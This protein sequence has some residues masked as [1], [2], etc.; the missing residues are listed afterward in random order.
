MLH[1]R[2]K[3]L[4]NDLWP[5][6]KPLRQEQNITKLFDMVTVPDTPEVRQIIRDIDSGELV[7]SLGFID[8]F[9]YKV[10]IDCLS[11][12]SKAA[13][14]V[15]NHPDKWIDLTSS[16]LNARDSIIKNL[17]D[18]RIVLPKEGISIE[19]DNDNQDIDVEIYGY[20]IRTISRLNDFLFEEWE[21]EHDLNTKG[22]EKIDSSDIILGQITESL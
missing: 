3:S 7:D 22:I 15:V 20:R 6:N 17:R 13:I 16:G 12:G 21:G 1:I 14:L 19:Y 5:N 8:R 4:E 9:G 2:V 10:D 11:T 18:G